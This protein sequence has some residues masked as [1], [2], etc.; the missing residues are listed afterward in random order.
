MKR[1]GTT[2]VF[3]L[4]WAI[5]LVGAYGLGVCIKE[6]RF[7]QAGFE[8]KAVAAAPSAGTETAPARV[9][10][11][12]V[13][14]PADGTPGERPSPGERPAFGG[15]RMM[16]GRPRLEDMSE[17]ERQEA[18]AR[19]R[20]RFG[21]RRRGEG[22]P[23]LSEEDREKMRAEIEDLRARWEDMSEQERQEAQAQMR[24]KY[25]FAPRGFGDR[26]FGG[27]EGGRRRPGGRSNGEGQ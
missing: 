16:A 10:P 9:A 1:S 18:M 22:M 17:Q 8:P 5:V 13:P 25:G 27:G 4:I 24:E 19:M 20:D 15:D 26:G 14:G 6:Y 11:E 21:G 2:M 12:S 23:Q 7:H 3:V